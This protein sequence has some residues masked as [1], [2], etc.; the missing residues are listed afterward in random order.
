MTQ[1]TTRNQKAKEE[2][3][4]KDDLVFKAF[5]AKKEMKNT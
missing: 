2:L 3:T 1:N 5:F 4:L